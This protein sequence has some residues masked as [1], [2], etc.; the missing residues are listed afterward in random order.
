[1]LQIIRTSVRADVPALPD[2]QLN[3]LGTRVYQRAEEES[4]E[5]SELRERGIEVRVREGS[6]ELITVVLTTLA[7]VYA[8]IT[9]YD[10]FWSGVERLRSHAKTVGDA[11]GK[12]SA[13]EAEGAGGIVL[14]T[15]VTHGHLDRLH[16][17]HEAL[18]AGRIDRDRAVTEI[19][20][21][22]RAAGDEV[23]DDVV[24]EVERSFRVDR[25]GLARLSEFE[26][27]RGTVRRSAVLRGVESSL[28]EACSCAFQK[29]CG[30][31]ISEAIG[32]ERPSTAALFSPD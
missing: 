9:M 23:T 11:L 14:Q 28:A 1:M 27:S 25:R 29:Q 30:A 7:S 24:A 5:L 16:K 4:N 2:E 21:I 22:F 13:S 26:E 3:Q 19:V 32:R 31:V 12:T 8:A 17:V 15:K 20:H 10:A 6:L 18:K